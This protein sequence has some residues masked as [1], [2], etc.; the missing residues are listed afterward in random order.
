MNYCDATRSLKKFIE[1]SWANL[2]MS[3]RSKDEENVLK[4]MWVLSL[5]DECSAIAQRLGRLYPTFLNSQKETEY[6][7]LAISIARTYKV[8]VEVIGKLY[9]NFNPQTNYPSNL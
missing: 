6:H 4:N 1:V 8:S 9:Y 5:I 7:T 2:L 3:N